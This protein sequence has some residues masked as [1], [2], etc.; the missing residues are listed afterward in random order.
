VD[1][2]KSAYLRNEYPELYKTV[3][4]AASGTASS[5]LI[6]LGELYGLQLQVYERLDFNTGVLT[7]YY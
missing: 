3:P 4:F 7:K 5:V 2:I 6:A 1:V